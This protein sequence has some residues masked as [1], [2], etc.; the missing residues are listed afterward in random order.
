ML[1]RMSKNFCARK[2][3]V[4]KAVDINGGRFGR[5]VV[6]GPAGS[7]KGQLFW[8]CRCDCSNTVI[9]RGQYLRS[10]HTSSCGCIRTTHGQ[11]AHELH[12]VWCDMRARCSRPSHQAYARYGGRGI[13]VDPRWENFA[14]FLADMGERPAGLTLERVDNDGPY[15]AE[16]CVWA[17]SGEQA[18]NTSRFRGDLARQPV[19][20]QDRIAKLEARIAELEGG[21][22]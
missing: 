12:P 10:G 3:S 6:T 1:R 2:V 22:S 11:H 13:A 9:V 15:S 17:T 4:S 21:A 8:I 19:W 16:N 20:I 18:R 7:R 14:S 5:L